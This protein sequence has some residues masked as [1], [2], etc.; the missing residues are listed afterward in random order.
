MHHL[1]LERWSRLDSPLHRLDARAKIIIT[2]AVLLSVSFTR[3]H[4][5]ALFTIYFLLLCTASL[6]ARLPWWKVLARGLIVLPFVAGVVVLNLVGGDPIRAWAVLARGYLSAVAVLLLLATTTFPKLL[7][8]LESL[9]VPRFFGM[10]LHFVYRYLFLLFEQAHNLRRAS[11]CRAPRRRRRPLF[12]AA[13]GAV[14]VLF[15]RSY[16]RAER[17]HHAMLARGFQGH[18]ELLETS[19]VGPRDWVILGAALGFLALVQLLR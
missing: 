11:R 12:E 19:A 5:I 15:A 13:A 14:A 4:E 6:L 9:G 1:A 16:G 7:R 8:G 17:I 3:P 2:L 18:F 10:I